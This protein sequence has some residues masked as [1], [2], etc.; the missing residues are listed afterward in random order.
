MSPRPALVLAPEGI[1][2][3]VSLSDFF[4]TPIPDV[5]IASPAF[6]AN[7][8]PFYARLRSEAPVHRV[9]LPARQTAWL[10]TRYEDVVVALKDGR[11]V[12]NK[13]AALTS[14][15]AAKAALGPAYVPTPG[16]KHAGP[17]P[18]RPHAAAVPGASGLFA[19][20]CRT[21]ARPNPVARRRPALRGS[22][23][24]EYGSHRRLRPSHPDDR[25]RRDAGRARQRPSSVSPMDS[26]HRRGQPFGVGDAPGHT[27]RHGLPSLH[28]AARRVASGRTSR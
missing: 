21:D 2:F 16:A 3:L 15:Q 24:R 7:P 19:P 4:M 25:H 23:A 11:F 9:N 5:D 17:R 14:E 1:V 28:P 26:L 27:E 12:K 6:K 10:I 18:A 20:P 22:R 8:Y 13:T